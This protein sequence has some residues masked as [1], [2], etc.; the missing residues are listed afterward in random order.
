MHDL[1]VHSTTGLTVEMLNLNLQRF[2]LMLIKSV[3]LL[4]VL[5]HSWTPRRA[6]SS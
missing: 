3:S 5:S 1:T 2:Y 6:S 4:S